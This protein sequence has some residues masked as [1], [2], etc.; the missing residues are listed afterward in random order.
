[1]EDNNIYS[2]VDLDGYA[3]SIRDGAGSSFVEGYTENL[4][5]YIT[6]EQVKNIIV[7]YS[8]G[9]DEDGKYLINEEVFNDTFEDVREWIFESGLSKLAV[10]GLVECAWDDVANEMVFWAKNDDKSSSHTTETGNR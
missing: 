2:I 5:E 10:K 7:G 4:D 9:Q 1:M 3:A 6:I 8:L